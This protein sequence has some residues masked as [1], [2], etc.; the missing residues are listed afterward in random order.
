M[1]PFMALRCMQ[2]S[3]LSAP[4][5]ALALTV[6]RETVFDRVAIERRLP[7]RRIETFDGQGWAW[8]ELDAI[9]PSRGGASAGE[10]DALRLLAVILAHWD[11]K[12]ANQRLVCPPGA[13]RPD[14]SCVEPFAYMHDLGATFGPTK[15]DLHNWR[16]I[17]VFTDPRGCVVSMKTLPW[18][19][20]T[21]PDRQVSEGGRQLL[22]G[23]LE[24]LTREQFDEL[25]TGARMTEAHSFNVESRAARSWT[26]AME[27]KIRQLREAG[28]CPADGA[29]ISDPGR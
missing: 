13:D 14:G 10:V 26:R 6:G 22:L 1:F 8:Y 23:L 11:N 20:A 18:S 5:L 24:Q 25:F 15:L 19:G 27:D 3:G 2:R 21:F 29:P 16:S 28:P 9:D 7:G 12:G 17:P 4:C